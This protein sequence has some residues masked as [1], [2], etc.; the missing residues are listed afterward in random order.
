MKDIDKK[1]EEKNKKS[2]EY[3]LNNK[4]EKHYLNNRENRLKACKKSYLLHKNKYKINRINN[5]E[6]LL[7]RHYQYR[8]KKIGIIC[9]LTIDWIKQNITSKSCVYCDE[10]KNIGCDRIDNTKGHT[11][12]NVIPSC[13]RCNFIRNKFFTVEEMKKIGLVI[14]Q[15]ENERGYICQESI[16]LPMKISDT[17]LVS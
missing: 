7:L 2:K 12:D 14:R 11:L 13:K 5:R 6:K 3:Y 10:T 9:D 8:D 17:C 4:K 1:R 16:K 15:I